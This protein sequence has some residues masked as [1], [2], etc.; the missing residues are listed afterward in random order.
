ME[1]SFGVGEA[2]PLTEDKSKYLDEGWNICWENYDDS[3]PYN[4]TPFAVTIP[5]DD[6]MYVV[7]QN[8]DEIAKTEW[9]NI[10]TADS[11]AD[12]LAAL[13]AAKSKL[14]QAGIHD[15]EKYRTEKYQANMELL[16]LD[17]LWVDNQRIK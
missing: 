10:V 16:G 12:A 1:D 17:T 3:Q 2:Y 8:T 15:L 13:E 14:E 5:A 6:P 4:L 11:E 9:I 7:K